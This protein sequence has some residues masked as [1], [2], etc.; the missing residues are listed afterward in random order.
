MAASKN[1]YAFFGSDDARV[2]EAALACSRKIAPPDDE[3]GLDIVNGAVDNAEGAVKAVGETIEAIQTLPFFGGD[4]A[5]WLQGANFFGDSVTGRAESTLG[6]AQDLI[7][8][9]EAGLPEGVK[10][11]LSASEVDKRRAFYKRIGKIAE[12]EIF[13]K[14]DTSRSGWEA[15]VMPLVAD[16]AKA[17]GLEFEPGALEQFVLTVGADTR[18]LESELEKLSLSVGE[19][20]AGARDVQ[21]IC[22]AT[23]SGAVFAIG[24]ALAQRNLPRTLELIEAQLRKG[25]NAFAILQAAIV[26]KVRGLLHATDLI[27]RHGLRVGRN[28]PSFQSAV[29]ALPETE[30]AHLPRKKDGDLNLYPL[31]LAAQSSGRFSTEE[32]REALGACLEANVRLVTTQ[33]DPHLVLCQLVARILA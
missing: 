15:K 7:D 19:G 3:F 26:P 9:L 4:K 29:G 32:L 12:V 25:E 28:Y 30:T 13:D 11:L 16:K 21:E 5:V 22:A 1:I 20:R 2:K 6:A 27:E 24:D 10:F 33:L 23:V 31:F 14:V 18:L 8:L 17:L